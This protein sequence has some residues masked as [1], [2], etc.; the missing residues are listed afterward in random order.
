MDM[1]YYSTVLKA[2]ELD[3]LNIKIT[4]T[5]C[6]GCENHCLLT[7]NMFDNGKK[8]ISGN[9][10]EKGSGEASKNKDLPNL[11]KYKFE[12]IG[13]GTSANCFVITVFLNLYIRYFNT[14]VPGN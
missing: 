8:F 2:D 10:C 4:H 13:Q 1:E 6:N 11:Y 3:K 12:R 14:F 7:I 5:R 9:R